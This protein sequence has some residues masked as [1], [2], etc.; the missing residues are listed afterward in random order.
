MSADIVLLSW[1]VARVRRAALAM[2][3]LSEQGF[4]VYYPSRA[5]TRVRGGKVHEGQEPVFPGY[6]FVRLPRERSV[7]RA[8]NGTRGVIRLIASGEDGIPLPLPAGE[9]EALQARDRAG[10]FRPKYPRRLRPGDTVVFKHGALLGQ[11]GLVERTKRERIS[12]LLQV[13]GGIKVDAP[14]GWLRAAAA[15]A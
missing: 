14:R 2:A 8:V 9:V 15:A 3:G 6:F 12:V 7:W 13:L 1:Y 11:V 4:I 5:T 10:E